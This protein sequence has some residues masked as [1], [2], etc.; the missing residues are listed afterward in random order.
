MRS[1][2]PDHLKNQKGLSLVE[3]LMMVGLSVSLMTA[4][5]AVTISIMDSQSFVLVYQGKNA[6]SQE[7]TA[8]VQDAEAWKLTLQKNSSLQCVLASTG[9][10][11]AMAPA[12]ISVYR[13]DGTLAFDA[14]RARYSADGAPCPDGASDDACPLRVAV[15]WQPLCGV[16]CLNPMAQL[17]FSIE[18]GLAGPARKDRLARKLGN[19]SWTAFVQNES[20]CWFPQIDL[21]D[22]VDFNLHDYLVKGR[23]DLMVP[24]SLT[25]TVKANTII[26]GFNGPAF[27]TGSGY[28]PASQFRL[29]VEPNA[30]VIGRS[31][32]GA[33]GGPACDNAGN[34]DGGVALL[35]EFP[36]AI[37]N[38]GT[39]AG[40]GG[41]GARQG[42]NNANWSGTGGNAAP[43]GGGFG[44]GNYSPTAAGIRQPF[45]YYFANWNWQ[46]PSNAMNGGM[47]GGQWGQPGQDAPCGAKGGRPGFSVAGN[48]LVT[49]IN[50][51]AVLGP[52]K[53]TAP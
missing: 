41:G 35:A 38:A 53:A 14:T 5:A 39:I 45:Q 7:L 17:N 37:S 50:Q 13:R 16:P 22:A 18:A 43:S 30:Y 49:W 48:S 20:G 6:I 1:T 31:G 36:I 51:G 27:R 34:F 44:A 33:N 21:T 12:P 40:G 52:L 8:T 47:A 10:D 29:V 26:G 32:G 9:C 25:I 28:H 23:C 11:P 42:A 19:A 15:T 3:L 2:N 4:I 24:I 46:S